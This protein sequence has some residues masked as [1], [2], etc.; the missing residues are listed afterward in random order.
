MPLTDDQHRQLDA[1]LDG[2]LDAA[3]ADR[4]RHWLAGSDDATAALRAAEQ[5]RQLRGNLFNS[6]EGTEADVDHLLSA[7]RNA[8]QDEQ[9]EQAARMKMPTPGF[10]HRHGGWLAMVAATLVVGFLG[11]GYG[12]LTGPAQPPLTPAAQDWTVQVTNPSTGQVVRQVSFDSYEEAQAVQQRMNAQ[13]QSM[14]VRVYAPGARE[15][16]DESAF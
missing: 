9:D 6:N 5:A 8:E 7:L 16:V 1:Y 3:A 2:E 11:I 12:Y 4:V 13:D 10:G 15:V 14:D